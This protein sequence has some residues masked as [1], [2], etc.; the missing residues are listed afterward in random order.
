FDSNH[1]ATDCPKEHSTCGMCDEQHHTVSCKVEDPN[2]FHC[3]NCD[4]KG[5]A[6]WSQDCPTFLSKWDVFKK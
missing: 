4:V 1:I 2:N 3:A 6:S 5:H